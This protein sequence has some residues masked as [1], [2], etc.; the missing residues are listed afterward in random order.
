MKASAT[1]C[2]S[3]AA[4]ILLS[5]SCKRRPLTDGDNNVLVNITIDKDIINYTVEEEPSLMR[6]LFFDN[7]SGKY[8]TQAFTPSTGD[9]V[10]VIYGRTYHVLAYNFGTETTVIGSE[11]IHGEIFATT[12]EIPETYRTKLRSRSSENPDELIVFSPDHLFVGGVRDTYIPARSSETPPVVIDIDASTVVESWI[13]EV[14]S[15]NGMQWVADIS[16]VITGLAQST[17]LADAIDSKEKVSVFFEPSEVDAN[18]KLTAR[19]NTFGYIPGETQVITLVITD[20]GGT[21]HKIDIDVSDQ[22]PD[23]KEQIIRVKQEINIDEPDNP[24]GGGGLDPDVDE[25][26]DVEI[27][28]GI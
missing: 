1:I 17:T 20:T 14:E 25:W 19:F 24:G 12:N 8:S 13:L 7:L 21:G 4:A 3:M 9:Y 5:A 28:I 6:I 2:I 10:S 16:G 23:N 27:D 11:D 15:I 18:G 26:D 22:L